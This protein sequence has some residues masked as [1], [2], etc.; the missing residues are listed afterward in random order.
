MNRATLQRIL[1]I[2]MAKKISF[3]TD[4]TC[5]IPADLVAK[6]NIIVVPVYVNYNNNSYADD[7]KELVREEYYAKIGDI[8]P[9]P[10]SAAMSPGMAEKYIMEAAENSDHVVIMTLA[11]ALSGVHNAM[12]LGAEKLP[13]DRYT[14]IDVGNLSMALGWQVIRAAEVAEETNGDLQAVLDAIAETRKNTRLYCALNTLEFL[15]RSGRVGW[16]A[17]GVGAL[18]QIKPLLEVNESEVKNMGRVRTF[19]RAIE[20][21]HRLCKEAAPLDRLAILHANNAAEAQ[22]FYELIK[23]EI[24]PANTVIV[25]IAP[26]IG[27]NIGPGSVGVA[28]VKKS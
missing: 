28:L 2:D 21:L 22:A 26:A 17:A 15:R 3:V 10:T 24:A 9:H 4:S 7:G 14:L 16:A 23:D 12:R 1:K 5:D 20:D 25:E 8:R 13:K 11:A 19:K 27:T 6:H 18:L